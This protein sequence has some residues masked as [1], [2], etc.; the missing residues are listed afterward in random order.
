EGHFTS[1]RPLA[2]RQV[3]VGQHELTIDLRG[4]TVA[5]SLDQ[6]PW[7]TL[8]VSPPGQ[9]RLG[10]RGGHDNCRIEEVAASDGSGREMRGTFAN[11]ASRVPAFLTALFA[12]LT[13]DLAVA[14]F[15]A[16]RG[17]LLRL[18]LTLL[19][20]V[21]AIHAL[22]YQRLSRQYP[23]SLNFE[24]YTNNVESEETIRGR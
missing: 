7:D 16:E 3:A 9:P 15:G 10:F 14:R 24:G 23:T 22:D 11:S 5:W 8:D 17:A 6:G 18:N 12:I 21:L 1:R 13:L 19:V 2:T 20:S 4:S